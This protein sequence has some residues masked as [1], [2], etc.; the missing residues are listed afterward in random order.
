MIGQSTNL[1]FPSKVIE[2]YIASNLSRY[3]DDHEI[4]DTFQSSYGAK[5]ST[6]TPIAKFI[7]DYASVLDEGKGVILSMKY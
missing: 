7:S 5:E 1:S 6:E 2:N 4:F 3:F